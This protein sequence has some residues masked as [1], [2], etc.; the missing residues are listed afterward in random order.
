MQLDLTTQEAQ[1][2]RDHLARHLAALDDELIHTDD[3]EM[4]RALA[5]DIDRLKLL[6]SRLDALLTPPA[7]ARP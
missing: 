5:A 6:Q 2:L 7:P 1:F 4:Q 3:F